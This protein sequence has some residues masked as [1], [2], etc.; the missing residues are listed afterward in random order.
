MRASSGGDGGASVEELGQGGRTG[1]REVEREV[2]RGEDQAV[3]QGRS[4]T[5]GAQGHDR[6]RGLDERDD[7]QRMS[8]L[9]IRRI[10]LPLRLHV[11]YNVR[12]EVQ[13]R[14]RVHFG[15]DHGVDIGR[16][17]H[18]RQIV[19]GQARLDSVDTDRLFLDGGGARPFQEVA[20]A[21]SRFGFALRSDRV[22]EIVGDIVD[23]E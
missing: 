22:F 7:L 3:Q 19:H 4:G 23:E 6:P 15:Y 5:Y 2:F 21:C 11:P 10:C 1:E 8:L 13:I 20:K 18:R 17:Q 9:L 12:N 14:R 16:L